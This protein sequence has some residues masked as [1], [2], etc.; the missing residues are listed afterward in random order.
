M[1]I[2]EILVKDATKNNPYFNIGKLNLLLY[3]YTP[4]LLSNVKGGNKNIIANSLYH[5]Y[6]PEEATKNKSDN[7]YRRNR[8][9]NIDEISSRLRIYDVGR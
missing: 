7:L 6:I 2:L 8:L 1:E 5:N 3:I 4:W 9:M